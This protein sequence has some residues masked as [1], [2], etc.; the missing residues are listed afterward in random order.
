MHNWQSVEF[1]GEK[2]E[3]E[4]AEFIRN[5]LLENFCIG[6][7]QTSERLDVNIN[8]SGCPRINILPAPTS[9]SAEWWWYFLTSA[10][11]P[12]YFT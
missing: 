6:D 2:L 4:A 1:Q 9:E 7:I 10:L 11:S 12:N 5:V 8:R 3:V